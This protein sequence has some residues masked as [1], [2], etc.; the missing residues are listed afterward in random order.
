MAPLLIIQV[1]SREELRAIPAK[2]VRGQ[3]LPHCSIARICSYSS[4]VIVAEDAMVGPSILELEVGGC[5]N[6]TVKLRGWEQ[7]VCEET[8]LLCYG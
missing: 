8:L 4:C 6:N 2:L 7:E 3:F 5:S 1:S